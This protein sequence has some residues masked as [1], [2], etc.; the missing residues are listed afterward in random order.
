VGNQTRG[1]RDANR[2]ASDRPTKAERKDQARIER[3]QIQAQMARRRRT[4]LWGLIVGI[5]AAAVVVVAMV[6]LSGEGQEPGGQ[7]TDEA[8]PGLMTSPAPWGANN[9]QVVERVGLLDL[10]PFLDQQGVGT[11][12]HVRLFLY[13]HGDP[14]EMPVDIAVVNGVPVSPLHTHE[15]RGVVHVE[16]STENYVGELGLF[17]DV[18]GLRLS[19][20]CLGAYC[21]QGDA[22]LQAYVNGEPFEGDPRTIPMEDQVTVALVYGTPDETPETIPDSFTFG[23]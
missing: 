3:E 18:W 11:H 6:A 17:F 13:V 21:T 9:E 23:A 10:P 8:L 12:H 2:P 1:G 14:V 7:P 16:A 15:D 19:A 20:D 22:T 5:A 4:R